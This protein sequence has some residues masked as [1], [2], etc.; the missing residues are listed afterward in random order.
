M[1]FDKDNWLEIAGTLKKNKLRSFLT[2]FG[3]F[4][5]IFMPII[6]VAA[7]NGLYYGAMNDF[8]SLAANSIFLWSRPTTMP[9]KG[10]PRGRK[11]NFDNDD[12]AVFRV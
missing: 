1:I 4:W 6:M 10:L 2:A 3:V 7:G 11:Y 9:F 12:I 5:G 8:Q